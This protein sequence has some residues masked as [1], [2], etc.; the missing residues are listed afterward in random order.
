MLK[1]CRDLRIGES[2][3]EADRIRRKLNH[4]KIVPGVYLSLFQRIPAIFWRSY[5]L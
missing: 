3:K 2:V 5:R 1:W 4:G